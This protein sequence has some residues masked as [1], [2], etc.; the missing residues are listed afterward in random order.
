MKNFLNQSHQSFSRRSLLKSAGTGV[1][2]SQMPLF[3]SQTARADEN[4]PHF[5]LQIFIPFGLDSSCLFDAR[6]LS[7]TAA[8]LQQNYLN[9]EPT[10]WVGSNGHSCLATSLVDPLRPYQQDFSVVNGLLM[11]TGFDGHD[12]NLN[13]FFTGNPF[14]GE[15]FV[16]HLNTSNQTPLDYVLLGI[17]P[18]L[19]VTNS[20]A[21]VPLD[22]R[23]AKALVSKLKQQQSGQSSS[24]LEKFMQDRTTALAQ[25][26]GRFSSGAS[27]MLK[28][29]NQAPILAGAIAGLNL[30]ENEQD[31]FVQQLNFVGESFKNR[32]ARSAIISI[33]ENIDAHA[34]ETAR[35]QPVTIQRI[36]TQLV[37]TFN[38]LKNTAFDS[39]RS[40]LDVTTVVVGSEFSRT[41]RQL[42]HAIDATGTDHN[43][44]TNT[45]LIGGKGI[46]AGLVVGES[47]RANETE[48]V[49]AVHQALDPN[50]LKIM[51]RPYDFAA[52]RPIQQAPANFHASDYLSLP[53]LANTL[54]RVFGVPDSRDWLAERNGI[55]APVI[56]ELLT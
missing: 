5:F 12:Q 29:N 14:G 28:G 48:V 15:S 34:P 46:K 23:S 26:R 47:D 22:T 6:P 40:F 39:T 45:V 27:A 17:L 4:D 33:L 21:G 18:L 49:S 42:N 13:F 31:A 53:S 37:Q 11:A 36:V 25:G 38:Y 20:G 19:N 2:L 8:N 1:V 10:P 32:V 54:Y 51:G 9:A 7:M 16:P 55:R 3:A 41:M 50:G 24:L 30:P 56:S 44:L 52:R 43:A 35:Q